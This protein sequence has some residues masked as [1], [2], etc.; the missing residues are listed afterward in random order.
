MKGKSFIFSAPSGAGKTT[1]VRHL[2]GLEELQ[3]SFSISATTRQ[4]RSNER[5]GEDYHFLTE[6]EFLKRIDAGDFVE[7]EE[8]YT[9]QFYGTLRSELERIWGNGMHA[10]FDVDVV[11]GLELKDAFGADALA[12]FVSPPTVDTLEKRLRKRG[13]ESD[14][15]IASR[16]KKANVEMGFADRFDV[17]LENNDLGQTL[18]NAKKLVKQFIAS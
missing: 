3:L 8:V 13:T 9:G 5:A 18:E 7:W 1:I 11:G 10:I 6:Q 4:P 17:I 2:L 16:I 15:K 14:E 12:V